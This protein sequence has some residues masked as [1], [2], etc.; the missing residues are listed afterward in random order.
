M[1]VPLLGL[2]LALGCGDGAKPPPTDACAMPSP[3]A[4]DTLELG[5]ATP[6]D[7]AGQP[8]AFVP[9]HDGDGL[10]LIRGAQGANM[11]G[12]VLR[13]SGASP[14]ACLPQSTVVTDSAGARVTASMPPL[15]TYAA[16]DGTRVTHAL[17]LPADYPASFIVTVAAAGQ[18]L[19]LHLHLVV[20]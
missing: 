20:P 7:L 8:A 12:F 13:V 6:A 9:L 5:A 2:A 11:L 16:S 4:I 17:W 10:S 3:R 14:P 1:L 18:S 19:T 15:A